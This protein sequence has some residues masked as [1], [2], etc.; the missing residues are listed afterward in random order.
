MDAEKT[1]AWKRRGDLRA[2]DI[3][4]VE[5]WEGALLLDPS[6]T[7]PGS[8]YVTASELLAWYF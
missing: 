7:S 2:E 6:A 3:Q 8:R 5:I 4:A 1:R